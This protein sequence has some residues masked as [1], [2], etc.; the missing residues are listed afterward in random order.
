MSCN[1]LSAAEESFVVINFVLSDMFINCSRAGT[2]NTT[3]MMAQ[4]LIAERPL[5]DLHFIESINPLKT[6]VVVTMIIC[7]ICTCGVRM[8]YAR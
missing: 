7:R 4:R 6:R 2:M 3:G 1:L 5:W 8:C